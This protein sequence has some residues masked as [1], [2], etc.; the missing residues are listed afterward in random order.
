M[1]DRAMADNRPISIRHTHQIFFGR[2]LM[3]N[4]PIITHIVMIRSDVDSFMIPLLLL[5]FILNR[6]LY[7]RSFTI[8]CHLCFIY[9]SVGRNHKIVRV[10]SLMQNDT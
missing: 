10:N 9:G 2:I 3:I 5:L 8:G 7:M 6:H 4:T 1:T